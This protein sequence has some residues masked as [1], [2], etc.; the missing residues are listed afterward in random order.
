MTIIANILATA[1]YLGQVAP[2]APEKPPTFTFAFFATM[3]V[4]FV[5]FYVLISGP[6]RKEQE[7]KVKAVEGM[8]KGDKIIS[9]GGIHGTV[10]K[11]ETDTVHVTVA[12]D[13]QLIFNKSSVTVQRAK[14]AKPVVKDKK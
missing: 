8:K 13:V 6:S 14:E 1:L 7:A 11:V 3:I 10:A 9:A 5:A 2:V 4:I 12:K